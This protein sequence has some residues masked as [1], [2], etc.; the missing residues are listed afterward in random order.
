MKPECSFY[1]DPMPQLT[2]LFSRQNREDLRQQS[3]GSIVSRSRCSTDTTVREIAKPR[4]G[5]A[6]RSKRFESEFEP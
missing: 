1:L 3:D 4:Q 5:S 6:T 2:K